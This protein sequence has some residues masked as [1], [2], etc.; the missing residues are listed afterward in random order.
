MLDEYLKNKTSCINECLTYLN[1]KYL[2]IFLNHPKEV[3]MNYY[4]HFTFSLK[5]SI[6]LLTAS[7]KAFVHAIIPSYYI[8]STSDTIAYIDNEI[9]TNGC[10]K[11]E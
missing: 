6:V 10:G 3:C 1:N 7:G 11:S 8:T 2:E 4:T 9:K 5:L